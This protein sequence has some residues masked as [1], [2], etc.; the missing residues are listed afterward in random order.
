MAMA[1]LELY[2]N[3]RGQIREYI[4]YNEVLSYAFRHNFL[5][6]ARGKGKT[7]GLTAWLL[8]R[9]ISR[10][11]KFVWVRNS[12]I[13]LQELVKFDGIGFLADHPK[14]LG[15][16]HSDFKVSRNTLTYLGEPIGYFV[17]LSGFFKFKGI[18]YDDVNYFIFDEFIPEKKETVRID[19]EYALMSIMQT[20]FRDRTDF[21]AFYMANVLRTS[22][23]ILEF[24]SFKVLPHFEGQKIQRNRK[25]NAGMFYFQ[26]EDDDASEETVGDAFAMANR[27][28][29]D[30]I[31][32]DYKEN[33]DREANKNIK[34]S[35]LLMYVTT[36]T[37]YFLLREYEDKIAV[38]PVKGISEKYGLPKYTMHKKYVFGDIIYDQQIKNKLL[39]FW[40]NGV[41]VFRSEYA[42]L[43][44]TQHLFLQ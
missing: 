7:Y 2:E 15:Y 32:L 18:N 42:L 10:G 34:R 35:Q 40:N 9:V 17:P 4:N 21:I 3:S 41:F 25:L 22:S 19:Y 1:L 12:E 6:G 13:V 20:V 16:E 23:N 39:E 28:T 26:N 43:Q 8:N 24:F 5:V 36:D 44:F 38:L 29:Q 11:Q 31:I 37:Q 30:N 27:Y 33:I 14:R